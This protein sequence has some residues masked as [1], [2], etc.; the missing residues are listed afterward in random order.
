MRR[1]FGLIWAAVTALIA[2]VA[3]YFSYEAGLSQGLAGKLP[4]GTGALPPYYWYGPHWG[5]GFFGLFWFFLILLFFLGIARAIRFGG[6]HGGGR[7]N[8]EERMR[9]WH[10]Q[11]HQQAGEP[12]TPS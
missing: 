9:E 10:T 11:A 1:G 6:R 2:G 5:F 12:P 3:S 4:A 7:W 8:Y